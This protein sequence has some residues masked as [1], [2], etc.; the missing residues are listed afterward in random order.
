[1]KLPYVILLQTMPD[2]ITRQTETLGQER[3]KPKL[4][5]QTREMK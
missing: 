2:N 4:L 1:M 5:S 3:V